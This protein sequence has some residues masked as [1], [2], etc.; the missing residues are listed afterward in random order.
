MPSTPD[1][2]QQRL[3]DLEVKF[4]FAEDLLETLH[5]T[6]VRQQEQIDLLG[7]AVLQLRRQA[8]GDDAGTY[9]SLRDDIPP[10]Y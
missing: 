7:R 5:A 8:P 2:L 9:R 10:H 1:A 6:V 4:S 3:I